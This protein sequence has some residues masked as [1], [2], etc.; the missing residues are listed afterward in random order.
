MVAE[1]AECTVVSDAQSGPHRL[2]HPVDSPRPP[3][4]H[5]PGPSRRGACPRV[6]WRGCRGGELPGTPAHGTASLLSR[7]ETLFVLLQYLPPG[8]ISLVNFLGPL[9]FVFLVQL[10][11]YPPNTEVNLI[12]VW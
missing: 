12:L 11:S 8:V 9:V 5:R 2:A 1:E 7:Q 4:C 3:G 10:E 6:T